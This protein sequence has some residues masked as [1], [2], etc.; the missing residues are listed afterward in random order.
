LALELAQQPLDD[1]FQIPFAFAQVGVFHLVKLTRHHLELAGQGPFGVVE[2]LLHPAFDA[3]F[4]HLVLQQHQ[5]H[6]EQGRQLGRGVF[7][8]VVVQPTNLVGNSL[9]GQRQALD[10]VLDL[11]GLDEVMRHIDPAGRDQHRASDGDASGD[12]QSMHSQGHVIRLRR[13]CR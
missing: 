10:F 5:V 7:G 4:E 9:A 13:T 1:L 11:F 8:Q 12:G 6:V 3:V 2:S